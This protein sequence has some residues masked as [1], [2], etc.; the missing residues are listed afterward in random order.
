MTRRSRSDVEYAAGGTQKKTI[1][2]EDRTV[3]RHSSRPEADSGGEH[4]PILPRTHSGDV[5][6]SREIAVDGTQVTTGG[7]GRP[8]APAV[9][10][11]PQK[12]I[13]R[14]AEAIGK[15][16][17]WPAGLQF[18]KGKAVVWFPGKD[19]PF[20]V[21]ILPGTAERTHDAGEQDLRIHRRENRERASHGRAWGVTLVSV[22]GG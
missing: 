20:S 17:V 10:P 19:A 4:R 9:G 5:R 22:T 18:E 2:T 13:R 11:A 21:E 7:R 3:R 15:T 1:V 14:F 16:F 12:T 8:V 6:Q